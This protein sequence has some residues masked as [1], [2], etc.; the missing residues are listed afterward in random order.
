MMNTVYCLLGVGCFALVGCATESAQTPAEANL[1][2]QIADVRDGRSDQI[3]LENTAVADADLAQ[4][5]DLPSLH[6]LL[7][8]SDRN[9]ISDR[10]IEHLSKLTNLEHLRLRGAAIGDAGLQQIADSLVSLRILNL[11]QAKFTD[12]GLAHLAR[13]PQLEQLRF[14]SPHVTDGGIAHLKDFPQLKRVHLIDVPITEA[15][16]QTFAQMPQ[17][18]SLYID[19]VELGDDAL[20]AL[21]NAQPKLHV[22][23]G[24]RHHDRDPRKGDHEH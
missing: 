17:L 18:E 16:L 10:G 19:G 24:Q 2:A 7:L 4:L 21:F 5:S 23:L 12:A 14:G 6:V 13:L 15:A 22:H 8:D 3:L 11:P 9:A 20:S 1:T